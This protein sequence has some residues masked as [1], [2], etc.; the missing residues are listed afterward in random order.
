MLPMLLRLPLLDGPPSPH[1][2]T[3]SSHGAAINVCND[4]SFFKM[5]VPCG[6]EGKDVTSVR[7][8]LA[9]ALP[10]P[11]QQPALRPQQQQQQRRSDDGSSSTSSSDVH[12]KAEA[13]SGAG[14]LLPPQLAAEWQAYAQAFQGA[15]VRHMRCTDVE[16][17]QL[18]ELAAHLKH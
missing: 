14:S 15:F 5:I 3:H 17:G 18:E 12:R 8:E 1:T 9:E 10:P 2:H 4:L 6:Q 13:G 16:T 11:Q 7:R